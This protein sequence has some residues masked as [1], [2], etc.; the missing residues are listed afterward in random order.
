MADKTFSKRKSQQFTKTD[1]SSAG[2]ID[3]PIKKLVD[4]L[5][6]KQEYYTTSSC[7][8]RIAL[9]KA[10][11]VKKPGLFLYVTHKK[12]TFKEF[13]KILNKVGK[14][15]KALIY[16]KQEPVILHVACENLKE[17]QKLVDKAKLEAGWKKSSIL[18][19]KNRIIAELLS[20]EHLDLPLMD[21]GK[22]LT[23]TNYLKLLLREAN[24][25][26]ERTQEK[27]KKLE[28]II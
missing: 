21:K 3:K 16:L 5:N 17:A 10:E 24:K 6:K 14:K 22:P 15:E 20:T 25:K 4:K 2:E 13:K 28:K 9:I 8:G 7:S 23:D 12:L 11:Q 27:I 18:A 19:T 1:K 26:L